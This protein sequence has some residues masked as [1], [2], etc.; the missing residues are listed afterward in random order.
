MSV[1]RRTWSTGIAAALLALAS[2]P[3]AGLA[4]QAGTITG[5][6]SDSVTSGPVAGA[7]VSLAGTVRTVVTDQSGA[8]RFADVPAG[9]ATLRAQRIGYAPA[10]QTVTVSAGGTV[11]A[12]FTLRPTVATLSGVVVVGYGTTDRRDLPYA[13][14]SVSGAEIQNVPMAGLDAALQGKAAGV[15]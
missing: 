12:N 11:A 2:L 1:C 4:Q 10:E 9:S 3:R 8:Y 15:Q 13:V 14:S 7:Q 6:V 5:T